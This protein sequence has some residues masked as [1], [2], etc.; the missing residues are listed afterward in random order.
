MLRD[1]SKV[2]KRTHEEKKETLTHSQITKIKGSTLGFEQSTWTAVIEI[3]A[4]PTRATPCMCQ[5]CEWYP[6]WAGGYDV[7]FDLFD[8]F[9]IFDCCIHTCA[10]VLCFLSGTTTCLDHKLDFR[11]DVEIIFF[12]IEGGL[13]STFLLTDPE[14]LILCR[15]CM[16]EIAR[17]VDVGLYVYL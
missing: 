8:I 9:D 17:G 2:Q 10:S 6:D 12:D 3:C 5:Y 15:L 7:L 16:C 11:K 4:P 1:G 14:Y 13:D